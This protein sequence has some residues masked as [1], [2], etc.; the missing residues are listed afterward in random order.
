ML[1]CEVLRHS[2]CSPLCLSQSDVQLLSVGSPLTGNVGAAA[3]DDSQQRASFNTQFT[4]VLDTQPSATSSLDLALE[5]SRADLLL[6]GNNDPTATQMHSAVLDDLPHS[7]LGRSCHRASAVYQRERSI[8]RASAVWR[9]LG[10]VPKRVWG[11]GRLVRQRLR[12]LVKKDNQAE[13]KRQGSFFRECLFA[14][15]MCIDVSGCVACH[16]RQVSC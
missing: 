14:Y 6:H 12:A 5:G 2:P 7:P 10:G 11:W 13:V 4:A 15:V 16:T 8:S 9:G 3:A 1:H